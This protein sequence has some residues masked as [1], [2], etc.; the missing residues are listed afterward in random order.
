M[1]EYHGWATVLDSLDEDT[2]DCYCLT[3]R[4]YD[5]VAAAL[6]PVRNE[7][8]VADLRVVNGSYHLWLAGFRNHRQESVIAAFRDIAAAA[9]WSYGVL[10]VHDDEAPGEQNRWVTWVMK[11]GA[12]TPHPDSLLSPHVGEVE[13]DFE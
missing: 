13:D 5:A 10:H 7:L 9:P 4:G 1:F 8:Q 2:E 6:P 12:V 11:R 3:Q